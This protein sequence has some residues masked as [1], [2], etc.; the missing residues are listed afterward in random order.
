MKKRILIVLT[1]ICLVSII[2]N[3]FQFNRIRKYNSDERFY[4]TAVENSFKGF[5]AGLDYYDGKTSALSNE[6]AIKNSVS[7]VAGIRN[8]APLSSY[9]DNKPL[10]L[11]LLNLDMFFVMESNEY[12]NKNI[13]SIKPQLT[14]ISK[15]LNDEKAITEL[16]TVLEKL[17]SNK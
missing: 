14:N 7:A 3:I 10:S 13:D 1:L 15:N 2:T 4:T 11:M 16:N 8:I 9:K 17:V 5:I 6:S 12:I